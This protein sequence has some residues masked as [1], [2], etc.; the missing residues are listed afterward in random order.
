MRCMIVDDSAAFVD[1]AR[2]L[3]EHGGITVVGV[4]STSA[5][6]L[7]CFEEQRPDVTL[8]D[9]NLGIEN[10]FELAEQLYRSALPTPSPV[11]LISTHAEQ[12]FADMIATSPAV[13]FLAKFALTAGAIRDLV[14]GPA[15]L[16]QDE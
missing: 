8:V 2:G 15:G 7:R 9:V 10:G 14:R 16:P 1:A 13:G 12:D 4:A 3:L 5:E 6:A 11:I